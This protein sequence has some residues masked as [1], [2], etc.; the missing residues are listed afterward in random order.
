M[1]VPPPC[2][3]NTGIWNAAEEEQWELKSWRWKGVL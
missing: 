3:Y 1:S 2:P